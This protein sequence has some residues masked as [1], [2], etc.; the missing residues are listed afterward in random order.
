MKYSKVHIESFGYELAPVVVTST[1]LEARLE[2]LYK[3]LHFAPGQLQVLTGIRE[4]RWW[5]PGYPVSRGATAAGKKALA[6]ANISPKD[7][8]ALVYAGVCRERFEP[9]TACRVAAGL[10]I[11][12]N[13]AVFDVSN[14]CLGVINGIL[15]VANRI[16]L[17]QIRAGL[18][19]SCESARDI[20][21]IMIEKMLADRSMETFT[22]SLATLTGG[23]GAVAVLLTDGSFSG[24]TR[25]RLRGGITMAAPEHHGLCLWGVA[26]DG[27][28]KFIQSMSTDAV[29]V[30]N[31]G[32]ELG[33][34]TWAAFL[35]EVG[36]TTAEVDRVVC[37]QVGSAHQAAILKTLG[38]P[39]DKDFT[40]F[41]Y[42]GN[43]GTVSL[44]LTAALADERDI[45]APGDKVA[46]LGI[47]SG[48]N[49]MMLGVDW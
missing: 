7:I 33:E 25:R 24:A 41:E 20:N 34:K 17:G 4:R 46:M 40:T 22:S 29:S 49:C 47:G 39:Q 11:G 31:Y 1:E 43:I 42:L 10:K 23:S 35:P 15:E 14:A 6:A 8:G 16:E 12:G 45:L 27:H 9:A 44:P 3:A 19:V 21:D 26:P 36:W 5:E 18:V 38:I 48:L 13:A 30:M 37:H 32:V 28:G 2:P